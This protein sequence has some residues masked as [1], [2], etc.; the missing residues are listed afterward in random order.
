MGPLTGKRQWRSLLETT[1]TK[2]II[3]SSSFL[4]VSSTIIFGFLRKAESG[5]VGG[6]AG[7][8]GVRFLERDS[9]PPGK[10]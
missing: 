2:A 8:G 5:D 10:S 7:A 4:A 9:L 1:A 3:N 6:G